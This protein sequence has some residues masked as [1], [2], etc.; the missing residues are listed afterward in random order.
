MK[1]RATA[2]YVG[3]SA[4]K[5]SLVAGLIRGQSVANAQNIL[6]HTNKQATVPVGK[7]LSSALANAQNNHNA[8]KGDLTIESVLV[9]PAPTIK[10][11][12]PRAK[13]AASSIHKRASHITVILTDTQRNPKPPSAKTPAP[14]TKTSQP[15]N[16]PT[17]ATTKTK[18]ET[19]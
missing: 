6:M 15:L 12:R 1:T 18:S 5:I 7:V 9:G 19:K 16:T 4:R 3:T 2:K 10:R 17:K 8:K 13:G 14:Q 11:F